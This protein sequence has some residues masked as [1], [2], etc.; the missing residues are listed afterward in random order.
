MW[1]ELQAI[2]DKLPNIECLISDFEE[3]NTAC[4]HIK[5]YNKRSIQ[6]AARQHKIAFYE[7]VRR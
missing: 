1:T 7:V 3:R 4:E 2:P 6:I 5:T